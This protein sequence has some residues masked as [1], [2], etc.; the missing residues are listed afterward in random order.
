MLV[1]CWEIVIGDGRKQMVQ[2]VKANCEREKQPGKEI[3]FTVVATVRNVLCH[4]HFFTMTFKMVVC[5]KSHLI[6][7]QN[8]DCQQVHQG[9]SSPIGNAYEYSKRNQPSPSTTSHFDQK[10]FLA[11]QPADVSFVLPVQSK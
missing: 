7:S 1:S 6:R 11:V 2:G 5:K 8:R 9:N 3:A 10:K 4:A